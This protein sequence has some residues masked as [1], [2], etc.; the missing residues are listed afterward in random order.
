MAE[1]FGAELRAERERRKVS[2]EK[3]CAETKI[4]P[5][6]VLALETGDYRSL[7]G[8]II[9]RGIVRAYLQS[10]KMEE[11]QIWLARFDASL[12]KYLQA[13][14]PS[15]E[16]QEEALVTFA[17][18]VRRG[19][20]GKR[21]GTGLRWMGVLLMFFALLAATWAVWRFVLRTR[22]QL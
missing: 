10:L 7:P 8:G 19:R 21:Q 14:G 3:L 16:S 1:G 17:D 22:I 15:R 11:E 12:E 13:F 9:R 2:V 6:H 5:H 20:G 4:R 18:N